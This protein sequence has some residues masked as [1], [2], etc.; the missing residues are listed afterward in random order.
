MSGVRQ[1]IMPPL[2]PSYIFCAFWTKA[3]CGKKEGRRSE[4]REKYENK[5]N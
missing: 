3:V 5:L 2:R 1:I 4:E